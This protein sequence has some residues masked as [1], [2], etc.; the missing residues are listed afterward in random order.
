[1]RRAAQEQGCQRGRQR[2]RVEGRDHGGDRDRQRELAVELA[3]EPADERDRD[4]HGAEHQRDRDDRAAHLVHRLYVASVGVRPELDVALD[5]L[6]DD[7]RVVDH[8]ADREHEPEQ[9]Q[10]IDREAEAEQHRERA[11]DR[12]RHREQ[13]DDRRA[14]GLQEHDHDE[15]DEQ[16][17]FE[18]GV[19]HGLDR[20]AHEDA[21][22]RRRSCSP[23]LP[24]NRFLSS[25]IVARTLSESA[26]ALEP[27]RLEDRDRGRR[28]VV[29]Q[30]A[31]RVFARA[32]LDARDV[33]QPRDLR[34]RAPVATMMSP[35]SSSV[36]RRPAC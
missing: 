17:R 28:L 33:L 20:L 9:R 19:D 27:G 7:D 31:Q 14:P 5:V 12:D 36:V 6:D 18:Q 4:E 21:S 32:Q 10:R 2:Q 8:D 35:N 1:M 16:Q 3:G 22:G 30:A 29:Q 25:S 23:R 15:H 24:G 11:D 26:S 34:R 13:R